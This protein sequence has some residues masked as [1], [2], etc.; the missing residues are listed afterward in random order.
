MISYLMIVKILQCYLDI[1]SVS[2]GGYASGVAVKEGHQAAKT[3][4]TA[5]SVDA[6]SAFLQNKILT[7]V[8]DIA[9]LSNS[10]RSQPAEELASFH[11]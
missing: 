8:I 11:A 7:W 10:L 5:E 2:N 1:D 9:A 6:M 4:C 3:S